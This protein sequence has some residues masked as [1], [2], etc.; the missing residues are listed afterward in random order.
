MS[1]DKGCAN[2]C[3][4]FLDGDTFD[5]REHISFILGPLI[6]QSNEATM[7]NDPRFFERDFSDSR[8]KKCLV[9]E[10]NSSDDR[11]EYEFIPQCVCSIES[12]AHANFQ[13]YN[14]HPGLFKRI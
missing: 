5:A 6:S 14:I 9:V 3:S 12:P 7:S 4:A 13:N 11:D 8:A 1:D 10:V 2:Q